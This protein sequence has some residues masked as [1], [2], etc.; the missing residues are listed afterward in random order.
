MKIVSVFDNLSEEIVLCLGR[1][2]GLHLGHKKVLAE[3]RSY[4]IENDANLAVFTFRTDK[5]QNSLYNFE[6]FC[7]L[8]QNSGVDFLIFADETPDFFALSKEDFTSMLTANFNVSALS[9]GADYTYGLQK[10]GNAQTLARFCLSNGIKPLLV[11]LFLG[12]NDQKISSSSIK[13]LLMEG[14]VTKANALLGHEYFCLSKVSSAVESKSGYIIVSD[15]ADEKT[16]LLS[17][18]YEV[19]VEIGKNKFTA[20]TQTVSVGGVRLLRTVVNPPQNS[21]V[22]CGDEILI[23]F[24]KRL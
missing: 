16:K 4:A 10:S 14:D 13:T 15:Y 19:S 12:D 18:E 8:C 22:G 7:L 11:P 1:F 5:A 23:K 3:A 2:D 24:I 6:E 17:G 20:V 21:T 9:F